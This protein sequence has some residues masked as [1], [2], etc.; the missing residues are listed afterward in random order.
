MVHIIGKSIQRHG[1][2]SKRIRNCHTVHKKA[3]K[4]KKLNY[5]KTCLQKVYK[6]SKCVHTQCQKM[7]QHQPNRIKWKYTNMTQILQQKKV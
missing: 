5:C 1:Q 7:Q 3:Q 2:I 4:Y 6:L